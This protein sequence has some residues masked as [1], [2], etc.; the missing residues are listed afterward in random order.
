M[1]KRAV[2]TTDLL[3]N[4]MGVLGETN[5]QKDWRLNERHYGALQGQ[6]KKECT[7]IYGKSLVKKWRSSFID[8]PPMIDFFHKDHPRFDDLYSHLSEN[9]QSKMPMGESLQ[10]VRYRVEK[11]WLK[12]ILPSLANVE[13]GKSVLVSTHKHVLRGMVHL[14]ADL[15]IE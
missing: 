4:E 9:E 7:D 2:D 10:M 8:P 5:V 15:S 1:L 12:Q 6:S 14:L 13:E 3:L 11:Y